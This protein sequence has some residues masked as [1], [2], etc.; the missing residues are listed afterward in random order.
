[1]ESKVIEDSQLSH[2]AEIN[3]NPAT[4]GRLNLVDAAWCP[5]NGNDNEWM[6]IDFRQPM[7]I[8]AISTQGNGVSTSRDRTFKYYLK[9]REVGVSAFVFAKNSSGGNLV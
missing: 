1:M 3:S 8:T 5:P 2:S 9:Y 7:L 6:Q 4:G